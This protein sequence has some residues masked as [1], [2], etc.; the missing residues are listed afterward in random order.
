[1]QNYDRKYLKESEIIINQE[2]LEKSTEVFLKNN[3][4]KNLLLFGYYTDNILVSICGFY[5]ERHFP[6][7]ANENG[8]IAYICNVYTKPEYRKKGYQRK[9]FEYC[10]E[11][12]KKNGIKQFKLDSKNEIA[13]KFYKEYGFKEVD[14]AYCLSI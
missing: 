7:Y 14:N 6:T 3:L 12:A 11:Y 4:N 2:E 8:E 9:V 13:I 10:L 5:L 1:M